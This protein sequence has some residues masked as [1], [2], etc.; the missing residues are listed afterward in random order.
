MFTR[1]M[2][3][4]IIPSELSP[5]VQCKAQNWTESKISLVLSTEGLLQ[6]ALQTVGSL[7][8]EYCIY[9]FPEQQDFPGL[10][11]SER[12]TTE[13][14]GVA[15][16]GT[17]VWNPVLVQFLI[18]SQIL[19]PNFSSAAAISTFSVLKCIVFL[20][21]VTLHHFLYSITQTISKALEN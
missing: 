8:P 18:P 20:S 15:V 6:K 14:F 5:I 16:T 19:H 13:L 7:T 17:F 12:S 21:S 9:F 4:L 2:I 11:L 3:I 1:P 10:E